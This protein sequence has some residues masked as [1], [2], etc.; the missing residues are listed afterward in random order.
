MNN[1][2]CRHVFDFGREVCSHLAL[3]EER[4]WLVT[5]GIGGFA[6]GTIAGILTRRYH[7][8]LIAALKPPLGRTLLVTKMDETVACN[9][10]SYPLSANRWGGGAVD[11][12]GYTLLERFH[13]EGTT[14]VWTY[15]LADGLL[16]KRVWMQPGANTTYIRYDHCRGEHPLVLT[17]KVL[18]N[19]RDYHSSTH[20]GDWQMQISPV[21]S[22]LRV[23]A[24]DGATPFY[25][26]SNLAEAIPQHTWY[27]N[28]YLSVEAYRGL[29]AAEDHLNAGFFRAILRPGETIT[30]VASIEPEPNLDGLSAYTERQAYEQRLLAPVGAGL[31][32]SGSTRRKR[33]ARAT[34]PASTVDSYLSDL[35]QHLILAADQFVVSRPSDNDPEGHSIIAGYPWFGDW[36]RD[37]MISL[38][39]LTL[40]TGRPEVAHSILQTF[41]HFVD[42]GMLPNRFPDAGETPEYNTVDATLWYIEAIR[43]YH[44]ATGDDELLAQLW[45]ALQAIIAW[46]Q[47]GTRY[48]IHVDPADGLLYAGEPGVQLTWMDAKVG[49]WVVTP[50]IGKPVEVNALWYN[51][52]RCMAGFARRLGQAA[53]EYEA[54]AE[55]A[56]SG[57][58]R[59]WNQAAGYCY[60][61][62][63]GPDGHETALRPNQLLAVSLVYSPLET[64]QQRA[65]VDVCARYLLTAHGLRSLAASDPAYVGHYGGSPRQRDGSYHQGTV[66]A[67]FIGPFVSAHVRVYRDPALAR[68][69]LL[70][71]LRSQASDN[72]GSISEIFD[73]DAPFLGRG[74]IAQAWS[75]AEVLRAWQEVKE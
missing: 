59:F 60:D 15:G 73:G 27:R 61:V 2:E 32:P 5:N 17:I 24:F 38:P 65:V 6:S 56:Q 45:P 29:D 39:G 22:G 40:T 43:A 51:A 72:I 53:D 4:E 70:S 54:S 44:V 11:P 71:L 58:A 16:E 31:T 19:Y 8:L 12:S 37:T 26:L 28:F 41:A 57:F 50:R 62:L 74:C 75:V 69:Y 66:W 64:G 10:D 14:P 34:Q 3:A 46:H 30:L 67:W 1:R 47:R 55:K 33:S 35:A 23:N 52:L 42:Q 13:L 7:G 63:D 18:V 9:G 49:D 21:G 25:L 48:N 68:S 20:A 36:G